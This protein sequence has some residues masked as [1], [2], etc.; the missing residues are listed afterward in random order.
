MPSDRRTKAGATP[1]P[2]VAVVV[3]RYNPSITDRLL[4]GA[5]QEYERRGGTRDAV[6]IVESPGS[7][8]LPGLALAAARTERFA[9]IVALGCLVRGETR[10][11]RYI[12]EAVAHGLV[13]V[14]LRTGVPVAFGVL[15]V[16]KPAQ[17]RA[18]AG[19]KKGNKGAQAMAAALDAAAVIARLSGPATDR[20]EPRLVVAAPDKALAGVK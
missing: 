13:G 2:R 17:A 9:A 16:D 18:R 14:T 4:E 11:D 19:G 20:V 5:L 8:E 6:T 1:P 12:A 3:S 7:Y 15:T 10:H